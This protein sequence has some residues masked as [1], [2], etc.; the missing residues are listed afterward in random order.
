MAAYQEVTLQAKF[1]E[2]SSLSPSKD[3]KPDVYNPG[4]GTYRYAIFDVLAATGGTTV[5]L[6]S[7]TTVTQILVKN[8][9]SSNYVTATFR[10]TGGGSNDQVLRAVAGSFIATGSVVTVA[11][12]LVLTA[13]TAA[14]ACE[15]CIIGT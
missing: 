5:D 6:G 13:N 2:S 4:A 1:S 8:K 7:F 14:V 10:T 15:V 9:D 3:F 11:N 12:D